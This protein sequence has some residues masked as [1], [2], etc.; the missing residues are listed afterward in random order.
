[1]QAG[2]AAY[3]HPGLLTDHVVAEAWDEAAGRWRLIDG[4]MNSDWAPQVNGHPV[5]WMDPADDQF[6]TGPR[7]WQAAPAGTS[8][9]ACAGLRTCRIA[10]T[11]SWCRRRGSTGRP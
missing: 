1:M 3:F 7:A 10:G 8:D 6:V 9:P 2:F 4:E 5:D 11:S